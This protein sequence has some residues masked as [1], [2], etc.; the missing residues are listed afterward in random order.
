ML[1]KHSYPK[2]LN[3]FYLIVVI[4]NLGSF[5]HICI[6]TGKDFELFY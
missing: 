6:T 4:I 1:I 5:F 3:D 2:L